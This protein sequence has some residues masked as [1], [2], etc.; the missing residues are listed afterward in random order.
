MK[1][2]EPGSRR[3]GPLPGGVPEALLEELGWRLPVSHLLW[4]VRGLPA[5]DSKS[6]LTLDADSR[7][8]RLE[9]DGWQI[10]YTRYAEQNGYWLPERLKLHGQDLDVTL[11]IRTGSRA[12]S[13]A[14]MSVRLSLPAPAKLNLFL[15]ILSRRDDGYHELQ[16]LFQFLDHGDEL[17]FEARQDGQVRL[18]TEI[19]GV[20]HDSNLIVRA[21]RGCRSLR[22]PA[23]RRHLAGQALAHG[24]GIGGGSD[25][26]T[27][28]LALNHLWQ[29]GWDGTASPPW[30][31]AW[32]PTC[33]SS[34]AD[35]RLSPRAWA[36]SS[37]R[38]TSRSSGISS[39]FR[40]YLSA[41]QKFF[42]ST[43]DTR[44]SRH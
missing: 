1:A 32:A 19:A 44:F 14:D 3:A 23:R 40:K 31:C 4:W 17:H 5:P 2:R 34:P 39:W 42:R 8:A 22:Q 37:P 18:H 36:K 6:R 13:A 30:A 11:V 16:T 28:L 35:A 29:L 26:A 25:A 33:R 24:G 10:E 7:L 12:S 38:W 41:Q 21:A 43:V 9:Q 27:T 15:H 20:P